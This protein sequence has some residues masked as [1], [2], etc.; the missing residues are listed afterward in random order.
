MTQVKAKLVRDAIGVVHA[1]DP[2]EGVTCKPASSRA[3]KLLALQL[4]LHE[5]CGEVADDPS[6]ILEYADVLEV[7]YELGAMNGFS[8]ADI[9]RARFTKRRNKGGFSKGLILERK[10]G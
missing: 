1:E 9:E 10:I 3:V 4:K 2:R 5:E 7:L 6:D 8:P